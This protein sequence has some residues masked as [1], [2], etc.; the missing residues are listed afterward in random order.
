MM[1]KAHTD[2][3]YNVRKSE[4][5]SEVTCDPYSTVGQDIYMKWCLGTNEGGETE[6]Q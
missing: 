6:G 5:S 3:S 4:F 1:V 2:S